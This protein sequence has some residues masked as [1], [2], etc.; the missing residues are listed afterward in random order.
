VASLKGVGSF[1]SGA[2]ACHAALLR[3]LP[4]ALL[5]IAV[6]IVGHA[7]SVVVTL[8]RVPRL[9]TGSAFATALAD[10]RMM[11]ATAARRRPPGRGGR[12]WRAAST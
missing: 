2:I 9:L 8:C 6:Y 3:G 11:G 5:L 1:A 12:T 10:R 4:S 7:V